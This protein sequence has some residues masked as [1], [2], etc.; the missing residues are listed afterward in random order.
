MYVRKPP[1]QGVLGMQVLVVLPLRVR[2]RQASFALQQGSTHTPPGI[3]A[4]WWLHAAYPC[5]R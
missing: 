1:D 2:G 3:A 4:G 5:C